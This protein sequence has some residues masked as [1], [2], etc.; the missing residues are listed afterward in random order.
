MKKA[1]PLPGPRPEPGYYYHYKHDPSM[2]VDGCVDADVRNYAYEVLPGLGFYTEDDGPPEKY[3][4]KYLPLYP[5]APV[6]KVTLATGDAVEDH[7]PLAQF[8][9]QVETDSYTGPR[10][11]KV[12]DTVLIERLRNI[13]DEMY[14]NYPI[15]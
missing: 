11:R 4:V 5:W 7:R 6:Y 1:L 12:T 8:M 13:A 15:T 3:R 2:K 14:G 9:E 10:F